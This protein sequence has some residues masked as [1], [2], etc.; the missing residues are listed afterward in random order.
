M[1]PRRGCKSHCRRGSGSSSGLS[2]SGRTISRCLSP[3]ATSYSIGP[4]AARGKFAGRG[5]NENLAREILELHTLGVGSGYTQADVTELARGV[6]KGILAD[7]F[8]LAPKALAEVV[9][10][11][12]AG[13]APMKALVA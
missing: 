9:F 13:V 10:P 11:D 3:R 8:G 4:E 5:L 2:P 1:R 12:S 6:L 7:Q